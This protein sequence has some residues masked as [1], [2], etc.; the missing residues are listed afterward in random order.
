MTL[1]DDTRSGTADDDLDRSGRSDPSA[2]EPPTRP[3]DRG[4][5]SRQ[6]FGSWFRD[7]GWR[8]VIGIIVLFIAL[9]PIWVIVTAAF[10]KTGGIN[11]QDLTPGLDDLSLDNFRELFGNDQA[12]FV[13]WVANTLTVSLVSGILQL[14]IAACG[15]FAFARLRFA[16]R[17]VGLLTILLSQMLPAAV[18]IT[19][20]FNIMQAFREAI[21]VLGLGRIGGLLIIYLGGSLGINA[22]L[23]KGFF[24]T[25][26]MSIDEAARIDGATPNQTFFRL[27]LPLATPVLAT[28]FLFGF[29]LAVNEIVIASIVIGTTDPAGR[30]A[31]VGLQRFLG[32]QFAQDWG[33]FAAGSLLLSIPVVL[34]FQYLQRYFTSGLTEGAVKG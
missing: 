9:F 16:G 8:H 5:R 14:F 22:W 26:P 20:L 6:S 1:L 17:K 23:I 19:A 30:T 12:P 7:T 33:A 29:V 4:G 13:R 31:A 10:A 3:P 25:I 32:Q 34:L 28:V 21:P 27:I 2:S 11:N 24:D 18:A 15:A